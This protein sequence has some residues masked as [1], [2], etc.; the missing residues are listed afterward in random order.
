MIFNIEYDIFGALLAGLIVSIPIAISFFFAVK[1]RSER[2][3]YETLL[4]QKKS[5]EVRL[6][7]ISEQLAPFLKEFK[8]DPKKSHFIGQ[9]ID[10]IIFEDNRIVFLEVKSG[11]SKLTKSQKDIKE[12]IEKGNVVFETMRI[13]GQEKVLNID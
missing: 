10:Y 6:G 12:N 3:R 7:Q 1:L 9:P 13:D 4:S 8:Y 5:S 2:I 11:K